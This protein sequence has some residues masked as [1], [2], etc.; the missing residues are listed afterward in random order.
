MAL[1]ERIL[2]HPGLDPEERIRFRNLLVSLATERVVLLSTHI[3]SE[4]QQECNRVLIINKGHIV[5]EDTPENLQARLAGAQRISLRVQGDGDGLENLLAKIPGVSRVAA[6]HDNSVE[7]ESAPGQDVRPEVARAVVNHGYDLLELRPIGMSLEEIF[8]QLTRDEPNPP[9]M[10]ARRQMR[11]RL[12]WWWGQGRANAGDATFPPGEVQSLG[13]AV[14]LKAGERTS[15]A[16][17]TL[18]GLPVEPVLPEWKAP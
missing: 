18:T 2:L 12:P 15:T 10:A 14:S 6:S 11:V 8:L 9:E 16:T 4:A 3:L 7:F 1:A 17:F 5:V 13:K